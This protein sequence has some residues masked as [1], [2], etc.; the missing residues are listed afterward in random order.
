MA[1]PTLAESDITNLTADLAAKQSLDA[2]LTALA[3]VSTAADKLIYATGSDAFSTTDLTSFGR[4]LI[5]DANAAAAIATLGLDADLATFSVP[6]STT[7]S[8]FGAT[9][10][11]DANAAAAIA[12]LGLDADLATFAVPASTTISAFGATLVDDA[13]AATARTTLGLGN[14][15]NTSD[16]NKPISTATQAALCY[17][18]QAAATGFS[19]ADASTVLFRRFSRQ[20]RWICCAGQDVHTEVGHDQSL[21]FAFLQRNI[22]WHE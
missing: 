22:Q 4:S 8:A 20:W 18:L 12:T 11:D 16:A 19:P 1:T 3:G 10:V 7:V 17:T 13:D 9:L 6:A 5:D 15:D 2:T 14:V 21:L